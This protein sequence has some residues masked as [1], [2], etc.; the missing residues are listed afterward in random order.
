MINLQNYLDNRYLRYNR[1]SNTNDNYGMS[2]TSTGYQFTFLENVGNYLLTPLT[3]PLELLKDESRVLQ[4]MGVISFVAIAWLGVL[5]A[6]FKMIGEHRNQLGNEHKALR[7]EHLVFLDLDREYQSKLS[8]YQQALPRGLLLK[9]YKP[10]TP[11]EEKFRLTATK[12]ALKIKSIQYFGKEVTE[13]QEKNTPEWAN[14][15]FPKHVE[16]WKTLLD[17]TCDLLG[18]VRE[19]SPSEIIALERKI[20]S[21]GSREFDRAF[22][23]VLRPIFDDHFQQRLSLVMLRMKIHKSLERYNKIIDSIG[24]KY[25]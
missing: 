24:H 21:V 14:E 19:I 3:V 20:P 23:W 18:A 25:A 1:I 8:I 15:I 17:E 22:R 10:R 16:S 12:T 2:K 5:G 4:V 13:E 11:A 6:A 9:D 7:A